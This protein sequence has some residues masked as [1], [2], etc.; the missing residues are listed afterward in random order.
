MNV[1]KTKVMVFEKHPT[2]SL[3]CKFS[4]DG[5]DLEQVTR[6]KYLGLTFEASKGPLLALDDMIV[7]GMKACYALRHR[8]AE[9]HIHDPLLQCKLFD[10]LDKPIL[11]YGCEVW[12]INP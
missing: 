3:S 10:A 1:A 8:C 9:L 11:S 12:A 6:F 5:Q 4:Y 2:E 7:A